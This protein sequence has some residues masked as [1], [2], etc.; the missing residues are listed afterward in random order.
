MR[1]A[2]SPPARCIDARRRRRRGQ[3]LVE[4]ALVGP[5]FFLVLFAMI[6][7]GMLLYTVNAVDQSATIGSNSIAALGR[8]HDADIQALTKMQSAGLTT[9]PLIKVTEIDV[10]EL[11]TN[12]NGDSFATN[13]DGSPQIETGCTNGPN[14]GECVDRY[15]FSGGTIVALDEASG[16]TD[17]SLCPPWPPLAR[18]V[19]NGQSSFVGL[20]I[21]YSYTFFTHVGPTFN[22]TATKTFRLE[23]QS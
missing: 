11:V 20:V 23:P 4:F 19:S 22:L 8:V 18:D 14:G 7:G 3:G 13:A 9:T 12:A 21:S 15:Q 5:V 6:D 2:P 17:T 1:R 16:C 10:E